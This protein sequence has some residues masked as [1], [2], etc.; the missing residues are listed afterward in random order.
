MKQGIHPDYHVISVTCTCGNEFE[1]GSTYAGD[2]LRVDVCNACHPFYTGQQA[3]ILDR[4]GQVD[5]FYKR[6]QVRQ[7]YVAEQK[8]ASQAKTS[9]S[10]LVSELGLG[11]KAVAALNRAEI[12][13]VG[14]VLAKLEGGEK[15]LLE[16]EGF[17]RKSLI[18]LKKT[19][20]QMGY[21]LP[22]AAQEIEI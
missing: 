3:R 11:A 5:R 16:V 21:Q 8:N 9:P 17:G 10:R 22:A 4:E 14:D 20:R 13:T 12:T 2:H 7:D 19:L 18:D 6:L 1:T 15:A